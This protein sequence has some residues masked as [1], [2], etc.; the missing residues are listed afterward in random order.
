MH[1][2]MQADELNFKPSRVT[3]TEFLLTISIQNQADERREQRY[4][5]TRGFLSDPIPSSLNLSRKNC[6]AKVWRNANEILGVKLVEAE[7]LVRF[8]EGL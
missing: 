3:E 8:T 6:L 1:A 4:I 7:V 5:L 2:F